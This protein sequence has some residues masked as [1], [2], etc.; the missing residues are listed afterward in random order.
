MIISRHHGNPDRQ[1]DK[2]ETKK[3]YEFAASLSFM[4]IDIYIYIFIMYILYIVYIIYIL[5]KCIYVIYIY[6]YR[7]CPFTVNSSTIFNSL[8]TFYKPH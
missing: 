3:N 8:H 4:Y 6:I 1:T 2:I 5:S 7:R